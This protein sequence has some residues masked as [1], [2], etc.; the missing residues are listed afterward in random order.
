MILYRYLQTTLQEVLNRAQPGQLVTQ[1]PIVT[2]TRKIDII[3]CD[4]DPERCAGMYFA[5]ETDMLKAMH[6]ALHDEVVR[7]SDRIEGHNFTNLY[8]FVSLLA[9]VSNQSIEK[10]KT[11]NLQHFPS[12][13]FAS[14]GNKRRLARQ[15]TS[16]VCL[17]WS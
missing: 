10:H 15:S 9:D 7:A 11:I 4:R 13:T 16:S 6:S 5:S 3:N 14:T 2:T 17:C 12:L 8:N 1:A